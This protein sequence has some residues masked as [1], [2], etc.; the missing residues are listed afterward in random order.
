[1]QWRIF[2]ICSMVRGWVFLVLTVCLSACGGG[3]GGGSTTPAVVTSTYTVGGTVSGLSGSVSLQLNGGT[4]FGVSS[5]AAFTMPSTLSTGDAYFL[6]VSAQPTGQTCSV[7]NGSGTVGSANV[8]N[9]VVACSTISSYLGGNLSGLTSNGLVLA[10]GADTLAVSSTSATFTMPTAVSYGSSYSITVHT[11]PIGQTCAVPNG[12]ASMPA[13]DVSDVAVS[14]ISQSFAL[15]GTISGLGTAGLVLANGTDVSPSVSANATAFTMRASVVYGASYNVVVQTQPSGLNCGVAG[16]SGT[17]GAA[18]VANIAV[19]CS[20]TAYPLSGSVSGLGA[21]GLVLASGGNTVN[22]SSGAN[23][24]ALP[25]NVPTG[26]TYTVTVQAQPTGYFCAVSNGSGTMGSA[27]VSN[28]A[29]T[30][31]A[32][33]TIG[34]TISGL[35]ANTGLVLLNNGMDA[36]TVAASAT[37]FTMNTGMASGL[38]YAISVQSNPAAMTCSVTNGTGTVASS[39]ISSATVTCAHN[40]PMVSTLDSGFKG[41]SAIALV[42][43]GGFVVVETNGNKISRVSDSGVVTLLA[44]S[45]LG[46]SFNATGAAAS[47]NAPTGVAVDASGNSY[48]ADQYNHLIRK[49]T[50]GGVVT[51]FAGN[52]VG[53]FRDATGTAAGFRYPSD[54]AIDSAGNLYVADSGNNRIRKITTSGVVT[55]VAGTGVAGETDGPAASATFSLP[56][57]VAVDA[58]G[59]VFVSESSSNRIRLIDGSNQVSTYAGTGSAGSTDGAATSATFYSPYH[60]TVDASNVVFVA[61]ATNNLIRMITSGGQVSTYAGLRNGGSAVVNGLATTATFSGPSG[62]VVDSSGTVFVADRLNNLIRK[63]AP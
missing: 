36:T 52:G 60:L 23:S 22:V 50:S 6:T 5:N 37:Q 26:G 58:S 20:A 28:V 2:S 13:N 31:A 59:R 18:N 24:F 7:A 44:G 33:K 48:V 32:N 19:T 11:Q 53:G 40:G 27:P 63:I 12:S 56:T 46:G 25:E 42:P 39:N 1:M 54:V 30:C 49:I 4:A 21:S 47:F 17:M 34:G 62:V 15:A 10:N 8:T 55:T 9:A 57:G 41:P 61:D 16:G 35:G 14:C 3:G 43:G 29:V 45:G 38:T 51:T